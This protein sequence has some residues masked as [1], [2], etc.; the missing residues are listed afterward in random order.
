MLVW[1][2]D[3]P[4]LESLEAMHLVERLLDCCPEGRSPDH[5]IH[6]NL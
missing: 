5:E 2:P 3:A 4:Q 6:E 1:A